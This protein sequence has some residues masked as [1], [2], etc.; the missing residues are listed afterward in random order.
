MVEQ[1]TV[2]WPQA[3][4]SDGA[5]GAASIFEAFELERRRCPEA[6]AILQSHPGFGND[7][8]RPLRANQDTGRVWTGSRGRHSAGLI[9]PVRC[10]GPHAF[11]KL[12]D[13][14]EQGCVVTA[15]ASCNPTPKRGHF[16][17]LR[18]MPQREAV[19]LELFLQVRTEHTGLNPRSARRAVDIE[20][21]TEVAQVDAD[22]PGVRIADV[23]FD[24]PHD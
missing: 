7:P 1:T 9:H 2:R 23:R 11:D 24:T 5:S 17:R 6:G 21:A 18:E 12:V 15:G 13:V 14:R 8:E 20:H 22:R 4:L 3:T 16:E 19:R 10:D